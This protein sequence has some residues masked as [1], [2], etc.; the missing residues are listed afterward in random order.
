MRLSPCSPHSLPFEKG[1][2]NGEERSYEDE[3]KEGKRSALGAVI[4]G[5]KSKFDSGTGFLQINFHG[6]TRINTDE[7]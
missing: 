6:Y 4:R 1:G 2:S 7:E 3:L 5:Q